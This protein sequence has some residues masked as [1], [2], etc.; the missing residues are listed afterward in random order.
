MSLL[1]KSETKQVET[2]TQKVSTP[3]KYL[4]SMSSKGVR[5]TSYV[6]RTFV[7]AEPIVEP[8][9]VRFSDMTN[10]QLI[11]LLTDL[12]VRKPKGTKLVLQ[13]QISDLLGKDFDKTKLPAAMSKLQKIYKFLSG[14]STNE[15]DTVKLKEMII[16]EIN[17]RPTTQPK[18]TLTVK[19]PP[20]KAASPKVVSNQGKTKAKVTPNDD[21]FYDMKNKQ[22]IALLTDL[23]VRKPKGTKLVLQKQISDLL[24]K[25]FDK[26]KLPAAMSKLQKI[27]KFLSGNSTNERDT[28][29]L[30]EMIILEINGRPTTQIDNF[31]KVPTAGETKTPTVKPTVKKKTALP[32]P[33]EKTP[34]QKKGKKFADDV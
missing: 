32:E 5:S 31:V 18:Q 21:R 16:L 22:L 6:H 30:K 14:N 25:D 8:E 17:G 33:E 24:G 4:Q 7:D 29:K 28:V 26:T 11:A 1:R 34:D 15:R 27:Y 2:K 19:K 12:G 3:P 20:Q 23:G 13:K 10:K 9:D